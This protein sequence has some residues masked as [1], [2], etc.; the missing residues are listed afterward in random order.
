MGIVAVLTIAMYNVFW[1]ASKTYNETTLMASTSRMA[2]TGLD[3]MII[4]IGT[5][6]GLREAQAS[7]VTS[8][9]TSTNWVLSYNNG[10]SFTYSVS[11]QNIVDQSGDR[12]VISNVVASTMANLTNGAQISVSVAQSCGGKTVTNTMVTFVQYRN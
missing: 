4:G 1:Y 11:K 2:S 8:S 7:T 12:V 6:A 5:N 10:L 9:S 3:R